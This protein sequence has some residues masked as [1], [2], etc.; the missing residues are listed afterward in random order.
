MIAKPITVLELH[1]PIIQFLMIILI[2]TDCSNE[3]EIEYILI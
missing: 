1:Y 2:N 3:T